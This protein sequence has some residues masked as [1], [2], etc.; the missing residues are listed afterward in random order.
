MVVGTIARLGLALHHD[1]Y[2]IASYQIVGDLVLA[3]KNVYAQTGRYNYGPVW[4]ILLGGLRGIQHLIER[5]DLTVLHLLVASLLT[6]V[7][8]QIARLFRQRV[9][10]WVAIIFFLNP[11]SVLVSGVHGQFDNLALLFGLWSWYRLID[12]PAGRLSHG[13]WWQSAG[14]LGLSLMA[15]HVLF[16]WPVWV[17]FGAG[18][19]ADRPFSPTQRIG[20]G[21][22]AYGL[23]ALGFLP[24]CTNPAALTGIR[25]NVFGYTSGLDGILLPTLLTGLD[26]ANRLIHALADIPVFGGIR[27]VW[28]LL[29]TA[30][31]IAVGR[32]PVWRKQAIYLYPIALLISTVGMSSQYL[33]IPMLSMPVAWR[34]WPFWVFV[35]TAVLRLLQR[36]TD[37]LGS[38]SDWYHVPVLS[39]YADNGYVRPQSWL[40]ILLLWLFWQ[41][42]IGNLVDTKKG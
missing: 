13:W 11:V 28:L 39:L 21:L 16:L 34:R 8:W 9:G 27:F 36:G 2:D 15:K 35:G 32:H 38:A 7:D 30:I 23:F 17:F 41:P 5:T 12:R 22:F 18:Q 24:F 3:G 4:A 25:E 14:L 1:N 6:I 40:L 10:G 26:P 29:L 33:V 20:Y 19:S 42:T 31:G 37:W